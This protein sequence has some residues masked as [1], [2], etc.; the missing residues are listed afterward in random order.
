MNRRQSAPRWVCVSLV[1]VAAALFAGGCGGGSAT[2]GSAHSSPAGAGTTAAQ[3]TTA[4]PSKGASGD[5]LSRS[6]LIASADEICKRLDAELAA[7]KPAS[8]SVREIVRVV[9]GRAASEQKSVTELSKLTPPASLTHDWQLILGYRRTLAGELVTLVQ[10][11]KRKD[12]AK[13]KALAASKLR[14]RGLLLAT[15]K[16]AGFKD[17]GQVG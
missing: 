1:L 8:A 11:A 13:I 16:H 15:A 9:P 3:A 14:V 4:A 2:A 12:A 7:V 17:C 10:A 6:R 5:A